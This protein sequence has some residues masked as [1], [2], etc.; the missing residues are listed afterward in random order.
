M[1]F[2]HQDQPHHRCQNRGA[3]KTGMCF[4]PRCSLRCRRNFSW[5]HSLMLDT[6]LTAYAK[7]GFYIY[8]G[9]LKCRADI[10]ANTHK[11]HR[12]NF[13]R[14]LRFLGQRDGYEVRTYCMSE[15][16]DDLRIHDHYAMVSN[17]PISQPLVK[18]CWDAAC[19]P[20]PTTVHHGP[21]R[22][23]IIAAVKYMTKNRWVD[24]HGPSFIF[25]FEKHSLPIT[26]GSRP[27]FLPTKELLWKMICRSARHQKQRAM[28]PKPLNGP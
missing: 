9:N 1:Y 18:A 26:W 24:Q 22:K 3:V 27:F 6:Q 11:Q 5:K 28:Q 4:D 10:P 19:W 23:A 12:K 14:Y 16:G 17:A 21:T 7:A 15:I 13:L 20:H 8:F 25:L 2:F